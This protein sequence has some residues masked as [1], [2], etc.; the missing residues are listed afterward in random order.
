[1]RIGI[2]ARYWGVKD[3]GIGR[4]VQ[5]LVLHLAKV[6][7]KNEYVIFGRE[8]VKSEIEKFKNFKW[9]KLTTRP[10]SVTEQLINPIVFNREKLDLLHVPHFNAP[11]FYPGKYVITLHD[12]IKHLSTGRATTTLP[13]HQY[14]A[15]HFLY[16]V[17]VRIHLA[18]ACAIITPAFFWK[19]YLIKHFRVA[20]SK[21]FVTY[22]AATKSLQA[23]PKTTAKEVLSRYGLAKPFVIYTGNLYPHKN[24]PFLIEA[25]RRFNL[26]HEHHLQLA[27]ACGRDDSFRKTVVPDETIRY[28]GYVPDEDLAILYSQALALV[29][30]SLIE[31]FGLIGLEAMSV[32]LPVISS[33]ATVLPE[34]YGDA[35]LYFDPRSEDQLVAALSRLFSDQELAIN[36][37]AAGRKRLKQFSFT[38]MARQTNNVYESCLGLRSGQ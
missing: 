15:K 34:I 8:E 3:T 13:F 14:L 6:D 31:G 5:N 19:D 33:N 21:I 10:Y 32:G 12:L 36:L 1:M 25:I 11:I 38:K 30:P 17:V 27:L 22:E 4:Y 9:V 2:D 20:D 24:V 7:K 23:K 35:A 26:S 29:Q 28:L 16:K 18:R 37:I